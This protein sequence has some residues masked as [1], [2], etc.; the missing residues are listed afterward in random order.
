MTRDKPYE[1]AVL[2][3]DLGLV[4]L[5]MI[6]AKAAKEQLTSFLPGLKPTVPV[7][8]YLHLLLVFL[9]AWALCADR[10]GL[11]RA[12]TLTGPRV[13]LVRRLLWT[14][15]AGALSMAAILV[16]A[17]APLNRSLAIVFLLV[18]TALLLL[19]KL[20][21]R[22]WIARH[23]GLTTGLVV[24]SERPE[25]IAAFERVRRCRTEQLP[26]DDPAAL[27]DRLRAG[28]IDE[29]VIAGGLLQER[30]RELVE[31]CELVGIPALVPIEEVDLSL[32]P[33]QTEIVES[34]LYLRY[35]PHDR[36]RPALVVKALLDRLLA[37]VLLVLLLPLLLLVGLLI[38]LT[39]P[40]AALFV[41]Q[42]GGKGSRPFPMLKF[43]TMRLGSEAERQ[44]LLAS[45]EMDGPVFKMANDPRVTRLGRFLRTTSIDEL[46]QLANVVLG[47]MSLV[48]PRPLPLVETKDLTGA[49][50][51]RLSMRPGITGLWQV[52][53]RSE[54]SFDRW[55]ALD[56]EY[57]DRWTLALD[58]AILL[59]TIP[60]LL[61]RRGAR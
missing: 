47:H 33:P 49:H 12:R 40:G 17:Q 59:R 34:T 36:D 45:N 43:R 10:I 14:Q 52:S 61:S 39:S 46:P 41:Q 25:R 18:S 27:R 26:I 44:R 58:L 29:V 37:L 32:V 19:T 6:I 56:L 16:A 4:V 8:D 57:V 22:R 23:H 15:G 13:E 28:G 1:R 9:P 5:S 21:Q 54:I 51:R 42:R 30:M 50:R 55:M 31:A 20:G 2:L 3:Q 38:R 11:H 35:Q 48:G 53:G 60:A 24:G 7:Q